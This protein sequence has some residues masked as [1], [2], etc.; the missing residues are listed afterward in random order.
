[1]N[2]KKTKSPNGSEITLCDTCETELATI[3]IPVDGRDLLMESCDKCDKRRWLAAGE[4]IDLKDALEEV[5][6]LSI[7]HI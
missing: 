5:Q 6:H 4:S 7:I 3:R 1:M 2:R